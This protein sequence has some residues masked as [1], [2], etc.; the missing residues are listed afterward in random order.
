LPDPFENFDEK[1]LPEVK[2]YNT[3]EDEEVEDEKNKKFNYDAILKDRKISD[4]DE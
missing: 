4:N 3:S 1:R 2:E